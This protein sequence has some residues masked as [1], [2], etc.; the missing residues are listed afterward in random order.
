MTMPGMN[1]EETFRAIRE[2]RA[3]ARVI[4]MSGLAE[5]EAVR[6]FPP[7]ALAGFLQKPYDLSHLETVVKRALT[8]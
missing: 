3:D 4:V 2:L 5:R 7:G 6:D 8:S 1:G